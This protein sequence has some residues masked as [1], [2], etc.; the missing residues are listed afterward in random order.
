[1]G[2]VYAYLDT[3]LPPYAS[4]P[5]LD[6]AKERLRGMME[7]TYSARITQGNSHNEAVGA[8]I[9]EPGNL[10]ELAGMFGIP[11]ELNRMNSVHVD[12]AASDTTP[13]GSA[14]RGSDDAATWDANPAGAHAARVAPSGTCPRAS[15]ADGPT[16]AP[17]AEEPGAGSF[18]AGPMGAGSAASGFMKTHFIDPDSE[19]R[20]AHRLSGNRDQWWSYGRKWTNRNDEPGI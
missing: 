18:T 13:S 16:V 11:T 3:M 7:N 5:R 2:V 20:Q 10:D 4:S 12:D 8:V 15:A 9:V 17:P 1:M 14:T 6:A 19:A